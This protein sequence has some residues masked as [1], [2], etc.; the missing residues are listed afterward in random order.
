MSE[1]QKKKISEAHKGYKHS[2]DAKKKIS[3]VMNAKI[4]LLLEE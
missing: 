2:E 3:F 1:E 4:I